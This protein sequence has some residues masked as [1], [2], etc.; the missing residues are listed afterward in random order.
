MYYYTKFTDDLSL[1]IL[2]KNTKSSIEKISNKIL[3][4][5]LLLNAQT[6]I[7]I[8]ESDSEQKSHLKFTALSAALQPFTYIKKW[9][10]FLNWATENTCR[11]NY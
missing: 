8:V 3:A 6:V 5:H 10:L 4:L 11:R 9:K 1:Y 7:K 2:D